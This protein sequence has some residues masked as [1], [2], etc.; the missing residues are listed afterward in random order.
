M[1]CFESENE[2]TEI[3]DLLFDH[4][5]DVNFQDLKTIHPIFYLIRFLDEKMLKKYILK[6]AILSFR[7]LCRES[8][9]DLVNKKYPNLLKEI[10][11][12][13]KKEKEEKEKEQ[14]KV[15]NDLQN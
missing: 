6:G 4:G 8:G 14:I 1:S 3:F 13:Q 11:E 2:R 12:N 10:I 9:Y 15:N 5:A 7:N